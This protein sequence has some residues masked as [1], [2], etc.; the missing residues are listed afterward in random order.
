[1]SGC[2]Y[3]LINILMDE[4]TGALDGYMGWVD[5]MG[6]LLWCDACPTDWCG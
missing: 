5:E 1:M 6:W 2:M 4:W 3:V